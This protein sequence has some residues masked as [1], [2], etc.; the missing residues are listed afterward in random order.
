MMLADA[1][2]VHKVLADMEHTVQRLRAATT[3]GP[4]ATHA[5]RADFALPSPASK[6]SRRSK[7]WGKSK[8]RDPAREAGAQTRS[9]EREREKREKEREKEGRRKSVFRGSEWNVGGS[10][11]REAHT[12]AGQSATTRRPT[13]SLSTRCQTTCGATFRSRSRRR[14]RAQPSCQATRRC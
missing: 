8:E 14:V 12:P 11:E 13:F 10:A 9:D 3:R 1:L 2:F 6:V 5:P 4:S 7:K